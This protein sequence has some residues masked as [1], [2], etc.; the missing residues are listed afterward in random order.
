MKHS[1]L[2]PLPERLP[3]R[4]V[5]STIGQGAYACIKKACP[6]Q[7]DT[8]VVAVKFIH[9]EY[10]A[11]HG[12]I[13]DKQLQM[14]VALH[15]HVG[16]HN[17]IITFYNSDEDDTWRWIAMELAEGGDLFDKIEADEGVGE[18]IAH[19]YFTQLVNAVG[20]MHSKGVGHRDIKPENILL[21][22]DGNLKL[23][24]F[25]LAT[26]FEYNGSTKLCTTLCGSPP[27]IAPEVIQCSKRRQSRGEG[28][29]ADRADI[30][31]CGVVLFVLLVG[32]TPW[33]SPTDESYEYC[34]YVKT[35][36]KPEDEL[37]QRLPAAAMSL[38]RG[39][40]K[41]NVSKRFSMQDV[42]R[43]P[44]FTKQNRYLSPDGRLINPVNMATTMFESLHINFNQDPL[45]SSQNRYSAD[46][47]A[48]MTD[49]S[50]EDMKPKFSSTQPEAATDD[51]LIDWDGPPR[52]TTSIQSASQPKDMLNAGDNAILAE[53]LM[54]EP[55]MSQ[56]SATPSVPLSRT[57]NAGTFKDI[58]PSGLTRFFSNWPLSLLIPR[59]C[60]TLHLL[61]VPASPKTSDSSVLI[62]VRTIDDRKCPLN[63]NIIV[64]AIGEGIAEVEFVKIKGDPLEWRRFFK[65]VAVL[66]KDAVLRPNS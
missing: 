7:T 2:A 30:W 21:A 49:Q 9:K 32:N 38:L 45:S 28:Y 14:E 34:D 1:Q 33:D 64:E 63:G 20:F 8:P 12:R 35:D 47:D 59:I 42:R 60:E 39:M 17:N 46:Q 40:M 66:C 56:F 44:W 22:S 52:L 11:R 24:D 18:D 54:D 5:S 6:L 65:K 41:I 57:Q 29:M 10:A 55:S 19:V 27:Y 13:T 62:R 61:H 36:A 53:R 48:V 23:A 16:L 37:W 25:G 50:H 4:I 58:I 51:M 26:L 3:F 43:H 31:S 15:K